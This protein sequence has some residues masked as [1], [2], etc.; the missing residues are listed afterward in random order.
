MK[1]QCLELINFRNHT[2]NFLVFDKVNYIV[3]KNNSGKSTIKGALQYAITGENEWAPSGR[4]TKNLIKHGEEVAAVEIE[5]EGLGLIKR[6]IRNSGSLLE[7]NNNKLPNRELEKELYDYF[8]LTND[9]INCVMM[10]SKF[11]NMKPAEQKD[12]LFRLT[13]ATLTPKQI[14]E[15]MDSPSEKAK[16]EILKRFKGRVTIDELD[17][18]YKK[19]FDDRRLKKKERDRLANQ[20]EAVSEV[21]ED[22]G[23]DVALTTKKLKEQV[24]KRDELLR[25]VAV[26]DERIRQKERL[27]KSLE[28]L[29]QKIKKLDERLDKSIV[30]SEAEE[31]L[32]GMS[33]KQ[34][35]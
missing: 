23:V 34:M 20:L 9:T 2:N 14:I 35:I 1:I 16:E 8:K 30:V 29:D 10:S 25:K 18:I 4:Q 19:F 7:V 11:L 17:R 5:I 31:I 24:K 28:H 21:P 6:T 12:F 15:F 13:N 22:S 33:Q 32:L 26:I 27:E 3:G